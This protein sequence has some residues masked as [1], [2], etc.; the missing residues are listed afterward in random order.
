MARNWLLGLVIVGVLLGAEG[1]L[2][3][4]QDAKQCGPQ[5]DGGFAICEP[6]PPS[7]SLDQYELTDLTL[8]RIDKLL[9]GSTVAR[10]L[11]PRGKIH[12]VVSGDRVG[13]GSGRV[14]GFQNDGIAIKDWVPDQKGG[15]VQ[16]VRLLTVRPNQK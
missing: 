15:S 3:F 11:D 1:R 9:D 2:V 6:P 13:V 7:T 5:R 12:S 16:R 14:S 8:V 4:A 10:V